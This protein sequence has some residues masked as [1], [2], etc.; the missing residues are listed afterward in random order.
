MKSL[1]F[2]IYQVRSEQQRLRVLSVFVACRELS[3]SEFDAELA[4]QA[5]SMNS[6]VDAIHI[7]GY[8]EEIARIRGWLRRP[9][10]VSADRLR[11]LLGTRERPLRFISFDTKAGRHVVS[12]LHGHHLADEALISSECNRSL[13]EAFVRSGAEQQAPVGTH[14][15]KTSRSHSDRF[16]RVSNLLE[17]AANVQLVAYWLMPHLWKSDVQHVAVDTSSLYAVALAAINEVLRLGGIATPPRLWSYQSHDHVDAVQ[18]HEAESA[19]FLISASTSGGLANKLLRQGASDE[20]VVTL[21]SLAADAPPGRVLCDLRDN[22]DDSLKLIQNSAETQCPDCARNFHAIR[23]SGDQFS[24]APPEVALVDVHAKDLPASYKPQLS[25]LAG[26]RVFHA[27]RR[28]DSGAVRTLGM[29]VLPILYAEVSDKNR[30]LLS[31]KRHEWLS[32]TRRA[33]AV[34]LRTVVTCSYPGSVELAAAVATAAG[35]LLQPEARPTVA[36]VAQ[37]SSLNPSPGAAAIVVSACIDHSK[38]LLA[39]SRALRD[40]QPDGTITYL[41]I[42]NLMSGASDAESLKT[43]ITFGRHGPRTFDLHCLLS[44]YSNCIED[45]PSW[46]Q[47]LAELQRTLDWAD[48]AEIDVPPEITTRIELL[49]RAPAAGLVED[50]FWPDPNGMALRLRS[51]FTLIADALRE[52]EA[53]QADL[54]AIVVFVLSNLRRA[55]DL[56]RRLAHNAYQRAVLSPQ[57]F[58]R[59]SD[60]VLQACFLR[61]ARPQ[62]LAYGACEPAISQQMLDILVDML[63]NASMP[64]RADALTEFLVALLTR[65]MTLHATHLASFTSAL[66]TIETPISSPTAFLA[67]YLRER[68]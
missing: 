33:S 30:A 25:A 63:P 6:P 5:S 66:A 49:Q 27:F 67:Q 19:V 58:A 39:V 59:Y 41:A 22:G 55:T 36:D 48:K 3:D 40:A 60:G 20:R 52:P 2:H 21:F 44:F 10:D 9:D 50:L 65:R 31:E 38:E 46:S 51:D 23:I 32:M 57:N 37:L 62:E 43:N 34:T 12:G 61:A 45:M 16:L 29:D 13:V 54:F 17:S 28:V 11:S 68:V 26:L 24:I 15:V 7:V 42:A 64:E 35:A 53:S 14:F 47:E 4:E 8:E 56:K 18:R 1:L